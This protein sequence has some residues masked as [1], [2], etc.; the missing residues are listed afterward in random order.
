M[1]S[2]EMVTYISTF[3]LLCSV[4]LTT[5]ST[6]LPGLAQAWYIFRALHYLR[7]EHALDIV[8]VVSYYLALQLIAVKGVSRVTFNKK[9]KMN[10]TT[11]KV[12]IQF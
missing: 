1:A 11:D 9:A 3:A 12:L 10:N 8:L 4:N 2:T 5:S 6:T 7:S